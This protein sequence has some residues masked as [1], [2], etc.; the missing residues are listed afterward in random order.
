MVTQ[1]NQIDSPG[2][3]NRIVTQT[4]ETGRQSNSSSPNKIEKEELENIHKKYP[5]IEIDKL[6]LEQIIDHSNEHSI[7]G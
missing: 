4:P 6:K 7:F 5:N 3:C 2:T 1:W